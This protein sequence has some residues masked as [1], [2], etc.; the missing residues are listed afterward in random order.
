MFNE[1]VTLILKI[2]KCEKMLLSG[3]RKYDSIILTVPC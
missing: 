2:F 1:I 3:L